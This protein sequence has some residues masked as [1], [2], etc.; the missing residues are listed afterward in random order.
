M[1][2]LIIGAKGSG[3]TKK[4]IDQANDALLSAKGNVVFISNVAKYSQGINI[5]IR[6]VAAEEFDLKTDVELIG[7]VRGLIA[8]NSDIE[9]I[10]IDGIARIVGKRAKES[11]A[12]YKTLADISEK[13][14]VNFVVSVSEEAENVP[15]FMASYK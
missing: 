5:N 7:F 15:E 4:I 1:I 6:F 14:K 8:G 2:Q 11:E 3:K 9:T 10:F 13:Y 12:L